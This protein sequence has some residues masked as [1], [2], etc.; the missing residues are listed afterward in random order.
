MMGQGL[1]RRA[2]LGALALVA[3]AGSGCDRK[4]AQFNNTL[5]GYNQRLFAVGQKLGQTIRPAVMG[6]RVNPKQVRDAY[7]EA[8]ATLDDIRKEFATLKPPPSDSGKKFYEGYRKLLQSQNDMMRNDLARLVRMLERSPNDRTV[9]QI[10]RETVVRMHK[11]EQAS[12]REIEVLQHNF[13][14]EHGLI[15]GF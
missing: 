4:A 13:A 3:L 6:D 14:S 9:G 15:R 5:A 2:L 8:I 10:I 7:D 12:T 11:R 1:G